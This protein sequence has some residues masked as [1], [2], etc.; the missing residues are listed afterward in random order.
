MR[1]A[2]RSPPWRR[3]AATS[4]SRT[5][6]VEGYRNFATKL[7]NAA[8]F[9][10]MNGAARVAG[11]D[12]EASA[13]RRST[14]GSSGETDARQPASTAAIEAY[15]FN[16]AANAALPF[17]LGQSLR[18]VSRAHQA[19]PHRRG[20]RGEGRDP[21]D[22]R[23]RA[24]PDPASSCT[25]SCP[26]SPRSCGRTGKGGG[27]TLL[28][29][30]RPG[31]S[32]TARGRRRRRRRARLADRANFRHS[33]GALGN[34]RAGGG[35]SAAALV[36]MPASD[37][38]AGRALARCAE[39]PRA[40]HPR[41]RSPTTPPKGAVQ[42]VVRGDFAALPLAGVIDSPPSGPGCRRRCSGSRCRSGAH[43]QEARQRRLRGPRPGGHRGAAREACRA[44][45]ERGRSRATLAAA[46]RSRLTALSIGGREPAALQRRAALSP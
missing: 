27:E 44:E 9:A 35:A 37:A 26:S 41:H 25:R 21:G 3:R 45:S 1:C 11:F 20:R 5:A 31:R 39:A 12:P 16:E 36:A 24:R 2:S 22:R 30:A 23:L 4:S 42:V 15:K 32:S 8:R 18:L 17:R 7:W 14:A 28:I 40:A 6:R 29:T 33:L 43:R 46:R 13:S 10:E 38:G 34:E 19:G